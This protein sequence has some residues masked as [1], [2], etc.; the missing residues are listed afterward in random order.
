LNAATD[1]RHDYATPVIVYSTT[2]IALPAV[3]T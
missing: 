1:T 3:T 2:K